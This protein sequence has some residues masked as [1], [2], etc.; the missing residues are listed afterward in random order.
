MKILFTLDKQPNR[1]KY[2]CPCCGNKKTFTRYIHVET[3]E[4]LNKNTGICDRLNNCG[5][6]YAPKQYFNDNKGLINQFESNKPVIDNTWFN[7]NQIISFIE[8][9]YL[10]ASM[11]YFDTENNRLYKYLNDCFGRNAAENLCKRYMVGNS[12]HFQGGN[13]FWQMDIN[14]KIRTGK[15]MLYDDVTGKR[16][17]KYENW[18]HSILRDKSLINDFHLKQCFFGEHIL[19]YET[20]EPVAIVESLKTALICYLFM[21]Q[22]I[23]LASG[24]MHGLTVEKCK[25]LKGREV[26]LFPDLGKGFD[27]WFAKAKEIRQNLG[28]NI[29]VSDFLKKEVD[30]IEEIKAGL[31]LEDYLFERDEKGQAIH[32][33]TGLTMEEFLIKNN[34]TWYNSIS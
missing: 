25:V 24:G 9:K 18:E 19:K 5:Y 34:G 17:K 23:W 10:N 16:I 27:N 20:T 11:Q 26:I 6:H 28:L 13:T 22:Y 7:N 21:P 33:E 14:Q 4:D 8:K 31:D 32:E 3:L 12:T 15:I 2:D 30:D 29:T 1:K